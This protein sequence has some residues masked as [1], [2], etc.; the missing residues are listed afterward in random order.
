MQ[1]AGA[2][3]EGDRQT[4]RDRRGGEP[5]V[6][7]RDAFNYGGRAELV[8]AMRSIAAAGI[9]PDKINEK[10]IKAHLYDP[11]M[12]DPEEQYFGERS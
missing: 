10:T 2:A 6:V 4:A 5:F 9:K 7:R 1:E 3:L 8:D 12:P 11:D